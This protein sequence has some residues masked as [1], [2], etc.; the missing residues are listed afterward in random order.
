MEGPSCCNNKVAHPISES[1][2]SGIPH[3]N[4]QQISKYFYYTYNR[5]NNS[6]FI[7]RFKLASVNNNVLRQQNTQYSIYHNTCSKPD[8]I[9]IAKF[10]ML[11]GSYGDPFH[12]AVV[13]NSNIADLLEAVIQSNGG[14][15]CRTNT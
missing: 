5:L 10:T 11:R 7:G 8:I 2:G 4:K 1:S 14:N 9:C 6:L 15:V 3:I 13:K 12:A